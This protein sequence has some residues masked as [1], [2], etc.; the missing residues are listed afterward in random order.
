MYIFVNQYLLF[1]IKFE[2]VVK[3]G[4]LKFFKDN[5]KKDIFDSN[6]VIFNL[7][8]YMFMFVS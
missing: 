7:W 5:Y 8:N 4:M 2:D 1:I 6:N 3:D